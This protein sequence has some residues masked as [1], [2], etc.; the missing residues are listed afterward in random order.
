M[1]QTRLT[2]IFELNHLRKPGRQC[3]AKSVGLERRQVCVGPKRSDEPA[4]QGGVGVEAGVI[5]QVKVGKRERS[6]SASCAGDGRRHEFSGRSQLRGIGLRH[7]A[8][9]AVLEGAATCPFHHFADALL[10]G[11]G[12]APCGRKELVP[13]LIEPGTCDRSVT[14]VVTGCW[15]GPLGGRLSRSVPPSRGGVVYRGRSLVIGFDDAA[16]SAVG[17]PD[18]F[19]PAGAVLFSGGEGFV[20]GCGAVAAGIVSAGEP[21]A[22]PS[23]AT[24]PFA[25]AG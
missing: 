22:A 14:I 3:S 6:R 7:A 1:A 13:E 11:R 4:L 12:N 18:P 17:L 25:D 15:G 23:A 5:R 16:P 24:G 9:I 2:C 10:L 20:V 21:A 8:D 19:P